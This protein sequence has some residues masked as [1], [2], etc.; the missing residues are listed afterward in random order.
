MP[1]TKIGWT[2]IKDE[3]SAIFFPPEALS[4]FNGSNGNKEGVSICPAVSYFEQRVFIVKSPY[5]F[6]IKASTTEDQ[7]VFQPVYPHTEI[8]E[9]LLK[10]LLQFQPQKMWR[11]PKKPVL[12]LLLPYVFFSDI[13]VQI[14]QIE[15]TQVKNN[16]NWSVIQGRYNIHDWQRPINWSIEWMDTEQDLVIKRGQA[17]FQILFESSEFD[18]KI[19]LVHKNRDQNIDRAIKSTQDINKLT[20]GTFSV[21]KESS[22]QRA[23]EFLDEENNIP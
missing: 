23:V 17:L 6:R 15:A 5:T 21:I 11:N 16:K 13:P 9:H 7:W 20:H 1:K 8:E 18:S 22:K 14:N 10:S 4:S 12:Q 19:E 2:Y 3:G